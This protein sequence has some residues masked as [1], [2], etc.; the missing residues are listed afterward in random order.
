M[1]G[2]ESKDNKIVLLKHWWHN[3][4]KMLYT[5]DEFL[6]FSSLMD[7]NF[8]SIEAVAVFSFM[9]NDGPKIIVHSIRSNSVNELLNIFVAN[10][11]NKDN[12]YIKIRIEFYNQLLNSYLT[13][14]PSEPSTP[15]TIN[16]SFGRSFN[17]NKP[18]N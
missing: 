8:D 1:D 6:T 3:Y 14:N 15:S 4:G 18:K 7:T 12:K 2:F 5:Y 13:Q 17:K 9:K 10:K 11:F 16:V